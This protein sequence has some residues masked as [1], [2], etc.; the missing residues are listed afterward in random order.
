MWPME[1][2]SMTPSSLDQLVDLGEE[3]AVVVHADVLEH[4]DR[5]DA[6]EAAPLTSR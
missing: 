4:A 1:C 6:V 3:L 2:S 5:D